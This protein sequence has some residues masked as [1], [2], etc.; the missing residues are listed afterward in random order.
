MWNK[1]TTNYRRFEHGTMQN[2]SKIKPGEIEYWIQP[3]KTAVIPS[4]AQFRCASLIYTQYVMMSHFSIHAAEYDVTHDIGGSTAVLHCGT[5]PEYDVTH[6][7]GG[8]T[9]V[10]HCS[11]LP[12]LLNIW[13][14]MSIRLHQSEVNR[15]NNDSLHVT[16]PQLFQSA[17]ASL[18]MALIL[19]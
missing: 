13:P 2:H 14:R 3:N 5:L 17:L 11:T 19:M 18:S 8:C 9:A 6:D 7:I 15:Q 1:Y 16:L 4:N 10:S 12:D